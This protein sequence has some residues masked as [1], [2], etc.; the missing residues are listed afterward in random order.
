VTVLSLEPDTILVL[1]EVMATDLTE[2][3]CPTKVIGTLP[4]FRSKTLIV[5]SKDPD[6]IL[7][8]SEVIATELT[9]PG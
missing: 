4:V 7:V 8:L 2:T 6:T 9:E 3:D 1:S 5:L